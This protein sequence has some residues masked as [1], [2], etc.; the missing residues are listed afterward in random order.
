MSSSEYTLNM[1]IS[2]TRKFLSII[3]LCTSKN[4]ALC[5][6]KIDDADTGR[7]TNFKDSSFIS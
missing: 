1:G 4:T 7:E 2:N 3:F 6:I 5:I